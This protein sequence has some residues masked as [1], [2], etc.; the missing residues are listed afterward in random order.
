MNVMHIALAAGAVL[1][2]AACGGASSS[3]S[4]SAS[5][6]SASAAPSPT[7]AASVDAR[8]AGRVC[9]ALNALTYNGDT[10]ADAIA[11]AAGAYHVTQAQVV[12]AIDH[13]CPVLKRIVPTGQ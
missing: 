9:A 2:L 4:T 1:A 7:A 3:S 11:T 13:R 6:T 10:G 5:S 8:T 12:Y